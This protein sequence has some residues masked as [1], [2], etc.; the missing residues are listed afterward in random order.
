MDIIWSDECAFSVGEVCGTVWVTRRPGEEYNEDFLVSCFPRRTTIMVW[1]AIYR[2][3]KS[4]LVIWDTPS[5]GRIN[6]TTYIDHIIRPNLHPWWQSLH[7]TGQT[8]SGYIYFLQDNAP[9]HRSRL[10]QA[11][12][13]EL[14]LTNYLLP[15]PASSPDMSPIEGIWCLLKRRIIQLRPRPTTTPELRQVILQQWADISS[16]D[17]ENLTSSLPNRITALREAHGGHTRF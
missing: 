14:G 8:N 4:H 16:E 9:A 1:G 15:W 3:Q 6:S 13:Q 17:I 5:W 12:M 2:N 11:A 7:S 10:S